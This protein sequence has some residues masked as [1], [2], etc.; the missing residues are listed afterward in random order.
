MSRAREGTARWHQYMADGK[1]AEALMTMLAEDAVFHSPVVHT[2]QVG[3]GKVFAYLDAASRVLGGQRDFTY[4]REIIDGD[5]AMLEFTLTLDDIHINGV[6]I[7][8]WNDAGEISDF[9]VMIRPL[10]AV[11][12]VWEGM[13]AM[14][15]AA[16]PPSP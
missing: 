11:N 13:A 8:R 12:K 15:S 10:K 16:S 14:L 5:Q 6:D 2:P 1:G 7:I 9:K 4:V 3:R